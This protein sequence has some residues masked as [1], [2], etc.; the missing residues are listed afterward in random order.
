M[1]ISKR[2]VLFGLIALSAL[3]IST[4]CCPSGWREQLQ[5]LQKQAEELKEVSKPPKMEQPEPGERNLIVNGDFSQDLTGWKTYGQGGSRVEGVNTV[6]VKTVDSAHYLE[7]KREQGDSDGGG[8]VAYQEPNV[9]V[10]SYSSLILKADVNPVYENG[11]NIANPKPQWYPEGACQFRIF[12]TDVNG[13]DAEWY[14]GFYYSSVAGAET[15]NWTQVSQGQWYS[16]TSPNLMDLSPKPKIIK[17]FQAYGFGWNF[18]GYI[19]N[20]RLLAK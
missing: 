13:K 10:S 19:T 7:V 16:Y 4:A 11:G 1:S 12:Y 9:D 15:A 17:K 18:T 3:V 6:K 2:V 20:I 5:N 8:A 14:H